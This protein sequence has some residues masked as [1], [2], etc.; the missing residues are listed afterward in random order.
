VLQ[1]DEGEAPRLHE[2]RAAAVEE[3]AR[4]QPHLLAA[5]GP[6]LQSSVS[7]E[8]FSEAFSSSNYEQISS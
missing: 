7:A 8:N 5:Q 2:Q 4:Q 3:A 6:I 1:G